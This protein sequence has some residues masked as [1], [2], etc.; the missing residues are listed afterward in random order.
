[1]RIRFGDCLLDIDARQLQRRGRDI[2]LSPK[3]FELLKLL[4]EERPRAVSKSELLDR[5][6]P[7][8]FVSD[9]SLARAVSEVRD[10]IG[11]R[12]RAPA[13]LRTIHAFGYAF[14]GHAVAEPSIDVERSTCWL[15]VDR[16]RFALLQ[17][18]Q[19]IGRDP[20]VA[21]CLDSPRVSRR[22]ARVVV[23]GAQATI[24]DLESKNGTFVAGTR[25]DR[26]LVL[27]RGDVVRIGPFSLT[28][29]IEDTSRPT[30]TEAP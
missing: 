11:D 4:V 20:D 6:W 21:I 30:E 29:G 15:T 19:T 2:P 22:H 18:E 28:F 12:A 23:R 27:R 8:V 3:G 16:R 26:P 7:G 10:A 17:G 5:I 14:A 25:V 9:S 1:V 13:L 24:E